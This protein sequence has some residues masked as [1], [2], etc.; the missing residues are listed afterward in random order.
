VRL[1]TILMLSIFRLHPYAKH[2]MW[3]IAIGVLWSVCLSV[4]VCLLVTIV[5]SAA[6]VEPIEVLFGIWTSVGPTNCVLDIGMVPPEQRGNFEGH[7]QFH[8]KCSHAVDI[9]KLYR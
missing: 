7:L 5:S 6:A 2:E 4:S 9:L 8:C 3:P 1:T